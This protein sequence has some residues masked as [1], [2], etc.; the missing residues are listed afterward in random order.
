MTDLHDVTWDMIAANGISVDAVEVDP[1]GGWYSLSVPGL[2]VAFGPAKPE[3]G[4][5]DADGWDITSWTEEDDGEYEA[6]QYEPTDE[7]AVA[8]VANLY[9]TYVTASA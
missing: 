2:R 4:E 8:Y 7:G 9:R 1:T 5:G 6:Y 3:S